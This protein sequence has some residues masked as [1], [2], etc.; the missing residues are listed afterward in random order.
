MTGLLTK[1]TLAALA[2]LLKVATLAGI[3]QTVLP[4]GEVPVRNPWFWVCIGQWLFSGFVSGMP[5]PEEDS[6]FFYVWAY[7]SFHILSASG[8]AYFT[9]RA[10]WPVISGEQRALSRETK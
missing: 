3:F 7:R 2:G 10:Q 5:E 4:G 1:C 6:S 9:H 8:T